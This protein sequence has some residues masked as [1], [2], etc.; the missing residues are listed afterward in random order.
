MPTSGDLK[1]EDSLFCIIPPPPKKNDQAPLTST[2]PP[3]P[4]I[5]HKLTQSAN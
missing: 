2:I 3:P 1:Y 5:K 4:T